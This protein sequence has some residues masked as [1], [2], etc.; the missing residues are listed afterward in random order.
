MIYR[1]YSKSFV[2]FT[3]TA[4]FCDEHRHFFSMPCQDLHRNGT[5]KRLILDNKNC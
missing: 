4:N 5:S 3:A 2:F 1:A